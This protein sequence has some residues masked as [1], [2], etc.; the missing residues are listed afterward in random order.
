MTIDDPTY[1]HAAII[2]VPVTTHQQ[3]E[4]ARAY[5]YIRPIGTVFQYD[6]SAISK[7]QEINIVGE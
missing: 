1:C 7:P 5:I 3:N 6:I 2:F 4:D